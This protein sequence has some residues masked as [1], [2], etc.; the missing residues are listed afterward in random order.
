M[1]RNMR[2]FAISFVFGVYFPSHRKENEAQRKII[3]SLIF[4][5]FVV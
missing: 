5:T 3:Y 1:A 2:F 4:L